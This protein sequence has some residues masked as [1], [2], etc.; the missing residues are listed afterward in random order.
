MSTRR[1]LILIAAGLVGALAA[2]A[3]FDFFYGVQ[4]DDP[5][6]GCTYIEMG[7]GLQLACVEGYG[8]DND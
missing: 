2:F 3:T 1:I 7:N 5:P 8:W 6:R 4:D